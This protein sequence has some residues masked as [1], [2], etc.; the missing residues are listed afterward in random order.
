[1]NDKIIIVGGGFSGLYLA[2]RLKQKGYKNFFILSDKKPEVKKAFGSTDD[3]YIFLRRDLL[4]KRLLKE[5]GLEQNIRTFAISYLYNNKIHSHPVIEAIRNYHY[6]AYG[7]YPD[8]PFSGYD[9]NKYDVFSVNY[10][11]VI[12]R[13]EEELQDY[14]VFDKLNG[15]LQKDKIAAGSSKAYNYDILIS[16]IPLPITYKM[17]NQNADTSVFKAVPIRIVKTD[18]KFETNQVLDMDV[19]SHVLRYV[20]NSA[21]GLFTAE[22]LAVNNDID[23]NN[24]VVYLKYGKIIQCQEA[25]RAISEMRDRGIL[26]LGRFATWSSHYDTEDGIK[27]AE[28]MLNEF[29]V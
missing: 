14:I 5:L 6:K 21:D 28:I 23:V 12:R 10:S 25:N 15:I 26:T 1:M 8:H 4:I 9:V 11:E 24:L 2:Y 27:Y 3:S 22:E 7:T 18:K 16:T 29:G 19:S 20:K 13:L 17:F